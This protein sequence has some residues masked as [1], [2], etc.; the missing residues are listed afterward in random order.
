[1]MK[2]LLI[3]HHD[4]RNINTRLPN[5]I[6]KAQGVY[7]PLGIAYIASYLEKHN[8]DVSILDS[9][10]LNLTTAETKDRILKEKPDVV[11]ITSMTPNIKGALEAAKLVKEVSNNIITV[12]GGPQISVFPKETLSFD[13]IDFGIYGEGEH[14]ML[15]LVNSIHNGKDFSNITGLVYKNNKRVYINQ[16]ALVK[17][18]DELPLPSRDLLP[19]EKYHC[20]IAKHPF[21][22]MITSRGCPFKC[23]FCFK[24]PSDKKIRYRSANNVVNEI[25]HCIEK[26]KVKTIMFYDNTFN[27]DRNHVKNICSEIIERGIYVEWEAST[28]VDLVDEEILRLMKKAGCIRLRYGVESGNDKILELMNKRITVRKVEEVFKSTKKIGIETF[29]YFMI[30]YVTENEKMIRNTINFAKKIDPDWVMFNVVTPLPLTELHELCVGKGIIG[31][32]Y[33]KDFVL[34]K[35]N[36]RLP[37][38]V[39]KAD[40]WVRR[41]YREFYFRPKFIL[42]K[43]FEIRSMDTIKKYINGFRSILFFEMNST[44]E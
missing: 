4:T 2:I 34:D 17:N 32:N 16:P 9:K 25:E 19:I 41:A 21:T 18:L 42:K 23:N 28:R 3:R 13:F 27:V 31:L 5:S 22:T 44:R 24:G 26:Y 29:A 6:N 37:F 14:A 33:W 11:G 1:M 7:P 35:T 30:G 15:E 36:E 8:Y 10:A 12:I 43:I 39:E 40:E 38:L 20:V